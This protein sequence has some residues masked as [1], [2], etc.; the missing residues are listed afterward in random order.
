MEMPKKIR[1]QAVDQQLSLYEEQAE[2]WKSPHLRAMD[3]LDLEAVLL[4]GL[5]LYQVIQHTA[6]AWATA[7]RAAQSPYDEEMMGMFHKW[8]TNWLK[9]CNSILGEIDSLEREGF[10]VDRAEDFRAACLDVRAT[11]SVPWERFRNA[12]RE[13]P[14][15]STQE[16]RDGLRSRLGIGG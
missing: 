11:L 12:R 2:Q 1:G 9:P 10:K 16:V 8:Y 4:F 3:C 5:H 14:T 13:G 7:A 15:K 6:D